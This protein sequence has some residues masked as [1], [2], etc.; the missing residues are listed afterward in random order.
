MLFGGAGLP[1]AGWTAAWLALPLLLFFARAAWLPD[2]ICLDRLFTRRGLPLAIFL[3]AFVALT[4]FGSRPAPLAGYARVVP[5]NWMALAR[6]GDWRYWL[7]RPAGV[8]DSPRVVVL[9]LDGSQDRTVNSRR[10][11]LANLLAVL[12]GTE[13]RAVALDYYFPERSVSSPADA[14]V[15]ALFCQEVQRWAHAEDGRTLIRGVG[16]QVSVTPD[17]ERSVSRVEL[18]QRLRQ[19]DCLGAPTVRSGH[20][21]AYTE[22][23][24]RIRSVPLFLLGASDRPALALEAARALEATTSDALPGSGL[25]QFVWPSTPIRILKQPEWSDGQALRE[26]VRDRLVLVGPAS[27]DQHLTPRG[28]LPGVAIHALAT[29]SLLERQW[30]TR[31]PWQWGTLFGCAFAVLLVLASPAGMTRRR[32]VGLC[33]LATV[34]VWGCAA[35]AAWQGLIWI[36]V[37]EATAGIWLSWVALPWIRGDAAPAAAPVPRIFLSYSHAEPWWRQ[38]FEKRLADAVAQ[39]GLVLWQDGEIQPGESWHERIQAELE[40]S[41]IAVLF[42]SPAFLRSGYIVDHELGPSLRRAAWG[43]VRVTWV[44][45]ERCDVRALAHL[46]A[47]HDIRTPLAD[48]PEAAR[49]A[50]LDAAASAL[51]RTA[52]VGRTRWLRRRDRSR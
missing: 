39:H 35:L 9:L 46:Q 31:A 4:V 42:V 38:E 41:T 17:G 37:A 47:L 52:G 6:H 23:D 49:A 11:T 36:D 50:Q 32:R 3:V 5:R 26:A 21:D 24:G 7:G 43:S 51:L 20:L 29:H 22:A 33:G 12:R 2:F 18:G 40:R 15:D 14:A 45:V 8:G 1:L 48:L 16:F 44:H 27:G 28:E 13:A 10:Q 30:F 25:L 19:A 34:V